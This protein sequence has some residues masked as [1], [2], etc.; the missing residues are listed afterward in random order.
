MAAAA[1]VFQAGVAGAEGIS[2]C[3]RAKRHGSGG[4]GLLRGLVGVVFEVFIQ[5]AAF[6]FL[7]LGMEGGFTVGDGGRIGP[8]RLVRGFGP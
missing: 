4:R 3:S 2:S 8:V 1:L 7:K 5:L 6:F